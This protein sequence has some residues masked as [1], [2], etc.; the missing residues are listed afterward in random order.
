MKIRLYNE[1]DFETIAKWIADERT[2]ALWCGNRFPYPL[3]KKAFG[4]F[5]AEN[6][7]LYNDS[8]FV[9]MTDEEEP[10][11]FFCLAI[12]SEDRSGFLKLIVVDNRVRNKGCGYEMLSWAVRYAFEKK[13]MDTVTVNVFSANPGARKCY[14]KVGFREQSYTENA[15]Q[16]GEEVWGRSNMVICKAD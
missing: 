11:G 16:F 6:V 2:H 10:F 9:V 4:D 5:L 8:P 13:K 1:N 12:D 14:E 15:L 3:E 7:L